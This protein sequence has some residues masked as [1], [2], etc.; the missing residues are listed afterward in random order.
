MFGDDRSNPIGQILRAIDYGQLS[1]EETE[2]RLLQIIDD[3]T[4]QLDHPSD[5]KLIEACQ[6]LLLQ[7]HS[8]E[9]D[10][11]ESHMAENWQA[12]QNRVEARRARRKM[13]WRIGVALTAAFVL[14]VSLSFSGVLRVS[15]FQTSSTSN[16]QQYIVQ[17]HEV[18]AQMIA[19]AI[20]EHE[21]LQLYSFDNL[22]QLSEYLG[23]ELELPQT[24]SDQFELKA[25]QLYFCPDMIQINAYYSTI[26]DNEYVIAYI[27]NLYTDVENAH[28]SIE[29]SDMGNYTVINDHNIYMTM[30]MELQVFCWQEGNS[31]HSLTI[32]N[33][34]TNAEEIIT[35]FAGG[36]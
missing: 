11:V 18:T 6:A 22:A 31:V 29:Q 34:I 32:S 20:A 9:S 25:G 36:N 16:E 4:F 14:I 21:D 2:R 23:F 33:S 7:M 26:E 5:V 30:N 28:I 24:V 12:I 27:L 19:T 1:R 3:E 15:W 17:G 13:L 35:E 8:Y 10:S